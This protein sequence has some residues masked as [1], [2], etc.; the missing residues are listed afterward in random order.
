MWSHRTKTK[1]LY[2]CM[3]SPVAKQHSLIMGNC[4]VHTAFFSALYIMRKRDI[5]M[6]YERIINE[7]KKQL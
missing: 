4:L 3:I 5:I 6:G 2:S 7:Y 1:V